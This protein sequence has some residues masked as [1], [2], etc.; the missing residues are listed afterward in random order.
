MS[1]IIRLPVYQ[2]RRK[3]F[4]IKM[5][6]FRPKLVYKEMFCS[7]E[8]IKIENFSRIFHLFLFWF[9]FFSKYFHF[10]HIFISLNHPTLNWRKSWS[11]FVCMCVSVCMRLYVSM[12]VCVCLYI[13]MYIM[14]ITIM[15]YNKVIAPNKVIISYFF[16]IPVFWMIPTM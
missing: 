7:W 1:S 12:W 16:L 2:Y 13:C 11:L 15:V 9:L 14:W 4:Q 8:N 3:L 5:C 10:V 6:E